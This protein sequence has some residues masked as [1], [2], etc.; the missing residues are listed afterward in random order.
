MEFQTVRAKSTLMDGFLHHSA[1]D[2][3]H[4]RSYELSKL[5]GI[6][7]RQTPAV[8]NHNTGLRGL[9]HLGDI[10]GSNPLLALELFAF[11]FQ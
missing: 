10:S 3:Q 5:V 6:P 11:H 2:R 1:P 8:R 7:H 4:S 9:W